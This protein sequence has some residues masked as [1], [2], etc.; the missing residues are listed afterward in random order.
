[1]IPITELNRLTTQDLTTLAIA[2]LLKDMAIAR[3]DYYG[4]KVA[5]ELESRVT[6][7]LTKI[8]SSEDIDHF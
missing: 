1:M 3:S 8:D 2:Q 6:S 4:E 7:E 5:T